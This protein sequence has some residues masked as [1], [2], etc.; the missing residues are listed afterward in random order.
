V[1]H[2]AHFLILYYPSRSHLTHGILPCVRNALR[3][4]ALQQQSR[5]H[6]LTASKPTSPQP[7]NGRAGTRC[8]DNRDDR[9]TVYTGDLCMMPARTHLQVHHGSPL[10]VRAR[11][12]LQVYA[13]VDES[14]PTAMSLITSL[15]NGNTVRNFPTHGQQSAQGSSTTVA[16]PL[17]SV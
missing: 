7:N 5:T 9:C 14:T 10:Q 1:E 8:T 3:S 12:P 2:G 16:Q 15:I 17:P 6:R 13:R 4:E 11:S